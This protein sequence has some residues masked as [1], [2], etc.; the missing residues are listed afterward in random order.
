MIKR[1]L[2]Y[3]AKRL[4]ESLSHLHHQP[5]GLAEIGYVGNGAEEKS[6]KVVVSLFSIERETSGGISPTM[7]RSSEVFTRTFPPVMLNLNVV[8]AAVY[9]ERRYGESLFVLSDTLR[10]IQCTPRFTIDNVNYTIE[11]LSLSTQELNNVWT[12]LGGHHY[13]SVICKI[14]RLVIDAK[15]INTG[16]SVAE[17]PIVEL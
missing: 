8:I 17:S 12:L 4:D 5:E 2:T 11:V 3:Y 7:Q 6:N 15:E 10:F 9:E 13:P 14:R 16:G 1:I